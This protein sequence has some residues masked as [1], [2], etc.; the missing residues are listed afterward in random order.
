MSAVVA[1][2]QEAWRIEPKKE[3]LASFFGVFNPELDIRG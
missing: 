2:K 3:A 1:G